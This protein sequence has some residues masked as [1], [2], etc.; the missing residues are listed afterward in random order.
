[1][2]PKKE[3]NIYPKNKENVEALLNFY[4]DKFNLE[5]ENSIEYVMSHTSLSMNQIEFISRKLSESY[6]EIFTPF[7]T[8][9][10][11]SLSNLLKFGI[12]GL[13][14][15][16][17]KWNFGPTSSARPKI[18]QFIEFVRR[19]EIDYDFLQTNN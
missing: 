14:M 1:M 3:L 19:T 7:F 9:G 18:K 11:T 10:K 5:R 12:E 2:I 4:F 13:T 15:N 17:K 6:D 8:R 16:E